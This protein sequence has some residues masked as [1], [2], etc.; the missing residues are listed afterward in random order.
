MD[1]Q[2]PNFVDP[3]STPF[4]QIQSRGELPHLY[5]DGGFYFVTFRLLD[6]VVL[7][8]KPIDKKMLQKMKP[9]EVASLSEPPLRLGSC[10]L[11]RP[12]IGSLV[13]DALRFFHGERY[14]LAAWCVMPNHVHAI[15]AALAEHTPANILH[16]WKS[17]TSHRINVILGRHGSVWERESFDHLIRNVEHLEGFID[18]VEKNPLVAGLCNSPK[19]WPYS[20]C[21]TGN[22]GAGVPPATEREKQPPM[23]KPPGRL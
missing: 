4:V 19:D 21:S 16:S 8:N 11:A 18:Y 22:C 13:Q 1:E 15:F 23:G 3:R 12:E 5:K 10:V 2:I 17:F 7:N 14:H 9:A 6:A 20:S